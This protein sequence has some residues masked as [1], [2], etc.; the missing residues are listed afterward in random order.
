MFDPDLKIIKLVT[1]LPC[2]VIDKEGR[3]C[4]N[5]ATVAMGKQE[6]VPETAPGEVYWR[7]TPLCKECGRRRVGAIS[8]ISTGRR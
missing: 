8:K 1:T 7:V 6:P 2:G 3:Q 5:P 4:G